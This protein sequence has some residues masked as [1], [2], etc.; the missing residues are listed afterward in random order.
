MAE[1]KLSGGIVMLSRR[2]QKRKK[3]IMKIGDMRE[4]PT[5]AMV[6]WLERPLR[7]R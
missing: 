2:L 6:Q 3:R 1:K 4:L 7:S 5:G